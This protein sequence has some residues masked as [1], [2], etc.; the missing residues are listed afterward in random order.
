VKTR[1]EPT[2]IGSLEEGNAKRACRCQKDPLA[3]PAEAGQQGAAW[4]Q[5]AG[6]EGPWCLA[7]AGSSEGAGEPSGAGVLQPSSM[8]P[9]QLQLTLKAL[10]R[11]GMHWA[12]S[13]EVCLCH[14]LCGLYKSLESQNHESTVL[15]Q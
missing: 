9:A 4:R 13:Q 6:V 14:S 10:G 2:T 11:R 15:G 5:E 12:R 3:A 7:G 1:L 8:L